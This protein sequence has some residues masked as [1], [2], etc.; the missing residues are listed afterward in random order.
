MTKPRHALGNTVTSP[1][2]CQINQRWANLFPT[3]LR[4][5]E[6]CYVVWTLVI[7]SIIRLISIINCGVLGALLCSCYLM[8]SML[9]A[10]A[11]ASAL[12][13]GTVLGS[14]KQKTIQLLYCDRICWSCCLAKLC[15]N[16]W[17]EVI[18]KSPCNFLSLHGRMW[19]QRIESI[20][21]CSTGTVDMTLA[22]CH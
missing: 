2:T 6:L 22:V 16:D 7:I 10:M 3:E 21:Y 13:F 15:F 9:R 20:G 14:V 19:T 17:K 1:D 8:L 4:Y 11:L 12:V 18:S 5:V